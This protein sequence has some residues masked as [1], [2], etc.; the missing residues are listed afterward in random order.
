MRDNIK[1]ALAKLACS[2]D[3][4]WTSEGLPRLDVMKDL[5]GVAVSRADITAA[6]TEFT[7]KNPVIESAVQD[8]NPEM[9]GSGESSG[10]VQ[11]DVFVKVLDSHPAVVTTK[12]EGD[13]AIEAE[14]VAAQLSLGK[15]KTRLSK[16]TEAMDSV[17]TRHSVEAKG[18]NLA[19]TVKQFQKSQ[20][21]QRLGQVQ[22][23]KLMVL[24]MQ[25]TKNK[26]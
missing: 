8:D 10:N 15:A 14:L 24:A 17:I 22:N 3:N 12:P 18:N 1:E 2:N 19:E 23:M 21:S 5:L 7:R 6:A 13:E 4:H 25:A 26:V 11:D 20:A 16:A 9:T